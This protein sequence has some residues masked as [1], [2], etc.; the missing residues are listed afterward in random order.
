MRR[1]TYIA[2]LS[3][4]ARRVLDDG[5]AEVTLQEQTAIDLE[6]SPAVNADYWQRRPV[7]VVSRA[8]EIGAAFGTWFVTGRLPH[9]DDPRAAAAAT[10][11]QAERLRHVLTQLGPAFVKIGQVG[12]RPL[13]LCW[14]HLEAPKSCCTWL[15]LPQG[16]PQLWPRG[17][18]R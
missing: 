2:Q 18:S 1:L 16:Y 5:C 12:D 14:A 3:A 7:A 9:S 6:Y 8:I 15:V 13:C 11:R 17:G 4:H 10:Q